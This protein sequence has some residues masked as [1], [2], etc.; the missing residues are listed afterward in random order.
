MSS[1][2]ALETSLESSRPIELYELSIGNVNYRYTSGEDTITV[3]TQIYL[4]LA[5]GRNQVEQGSDQANRTLLITMP[6]NNEFAARYVGL[7]PG[8]RAFVNIYRYQRDESPAFST[9]VLIFKGLV[10]SVRFSEDGTVA[11]VAVRSIETAL[12]RIVPR[13]TYM[14]MCNHFLFDAG[15]KVNPAL[16]NH[17]G[18]VTAVNGNDVTVAGLAA[19]GYDVVGGYARPTTVQDFR[20]VLAQS[21]DTV[22]L[23]LPFADS[24]LGGDLQLFAGC[25]HI[26]D[27]DCALVF[28]NVENFGGFGFVPNKNPFQVGIK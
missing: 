25:D 13:F 11:E 28:D 18:T 26:V 2:N 8:D 17:V 24:V 15:C 9:Q 16:F 27:G 23:L 3:G 10:Q 19:S 1:F 20:M 7:V 21:G 22:T 12:N 5:I 4:P 14:G 6:A